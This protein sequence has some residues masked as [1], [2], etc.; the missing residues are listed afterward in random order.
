MEELVGNLSA[1]S[2]R[3][4]SREVRQAGAKQC[5]QQGYRHRVDEVHTNTAGQQP[6]QCFQREGHI[7]RILLHKAQEYESENRHAQHQQNHCEDHIHQDI[8]GSIFFNVIR[9]GNGAGRS[10]GAAVAQIDEERHHRRGQQHNTNHGAAGEVHHAD[11]FPVHIHRQSHDCAA[12]HQRDTVVRKDHGEH[13]QHCR[14]DG[15]AHGGQCDRQ[16]LLPLVQ[17]QNAGCLINGVIL[18]ME[19]VVEHQKCHREGV[20]HAAHNNALVAIEANVQPQQI[21]QQAIVT[22]QKHQAHTMGDT[23]DQH[24]YCKQHYKHR[25]QIN[26]GTVQQPGQAK[27]KEDGNRCCEN[28]GHQ[29]MFQHGPEL[30]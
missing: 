5:C 14:N 2:C 6:V 9:F 26:I 4:I 19:G 1:A 3:N 23:G 12:G 29:R 13:R 20:Q 28:C 8:S 11:D 16:K 18:V 21:G 7:Y 10:M 25:L 27:G 15:S 17:T 30:S 22:Q 24:G